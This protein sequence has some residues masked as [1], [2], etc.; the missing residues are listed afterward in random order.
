MI[1]FHDRFTF[2]FHDDKLS[3][4]YFIKLVHFLTLSL[5]I[6]KLIFILQWLKSSANIH[7]S[8]N[9]VTVV[10]LMFKML[11]TY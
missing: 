7:N 1:C 11:H 5:Y 9:K 8:I 6:F 10:I 4:F 2:L 3:V